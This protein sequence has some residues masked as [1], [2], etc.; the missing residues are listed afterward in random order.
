[1]RTQDLQADS[2]FDATEA[3]AAQATASVRRSHVQ[4]PWAV[5]ALHWSSVAAMVAAASSVL[6]RDVVEN[7]GARTLLLDAHRQAGLF[8]LLALVL[9]LI[10]RM[11]KGMA[12]NA[13]DMAWPMKAAALGA[14]LALY[15]MLLA[16]PLL[17]WA[18]VN[19]HDTPLSLFG[20]VHLPNIVEADS[21]VADTLT[22][23]HV[24]AAWGM[25]ALIVAH[26]AAALWHHHVRK[27]G[28]LLA[29][30]PKKK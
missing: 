5:R 15:G 21:D 11:R 6:V 17:G 7:A 29:M 18:V 27:D 14:H 4:H 9:R 2:S 28:V 25:L 26:V 3:V 10:V 22:D 8:V 30:L 19:A 16:L 20:L 12:D 23:Y 24:L 1:M 13:H